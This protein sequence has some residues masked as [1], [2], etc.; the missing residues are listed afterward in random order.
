[1]QG[2]RQAANI[3]RRYAK[4]KIEKKKKK[5]ERNLCFNPYHYSINGLFLGELILVEFYNFI[6][7]P[8]FTGIFSHR[9][10]FYTGI[11]SARIFLILLLCFQIDS[12]W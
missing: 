11:P 7:Y 4:F 2:N 5:K 1:M 8:M 9:Y 3:Q 10:F 6:E 12:G